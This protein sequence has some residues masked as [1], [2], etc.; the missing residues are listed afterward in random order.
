MKGQYEFYT[1]E[2]ERYAKEFRHGEKLMKQYYIPILKELGAKT[3]LDLGCGPGN[4]TKLLVDEG[5][6]VVGVDQSLPFVQ[7]ASK[8]FPALLDD[9][10]TLGHVLTKYRDKLPFDAAIAVF[11]TL[12]HLAH[13]RDLVHHFRAVH[14]VAKY[15]IFDFPAFVN[16]AVSPKENLHEEYHFDRAGRVRM[17]IKSGDKE[18]GILLSMLTPL[19]I[20]TIAPLTGW[21]VERRLADGKEFN[22][23]DTLFDE[24]HR[25]IYVL[26]R[27]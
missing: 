21:R 13:A 11:T 12:P 25:F 16:L 27:V 24:V 7:E 1:E 15:Y 18:Y 8:H 3:V 4:A 14:R 6:D 2:H 19:Y 20:D 26:R 10:R 22:A 17:V 9:L 5:F 23:R